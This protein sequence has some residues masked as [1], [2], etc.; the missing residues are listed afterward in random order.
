MVRRAIPVYLVRLLGANPDGT[1]RDSR[2]LGSA[3]GSQSHW[4]GAR[5]PFTWFGCWASIPMVWRAIPVYLNLA[6]A[7]PNAT[8]RDSRLLGSTVGSQSPWY[9]ARLPFT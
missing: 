7:N 3:V 9:G 2:L 4:Y 8:A 1:A 6:R 5:F